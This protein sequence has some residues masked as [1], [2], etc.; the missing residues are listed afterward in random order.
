[1][2]ISYAIIQDE[3]PCPYYMRTRDCKFKIACKFHH[4]QPTKDVPVQG[5][6]A[7]GSTGLFMLPSSGGLPSWSQNA[8]YLSAPA[9]QGIV[10]A[11]GWSTYMVSKSSS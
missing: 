5:P 1:M 10:T 11:P 8:T 2:L 7:Y 3:K 6:G 9:S 4:P